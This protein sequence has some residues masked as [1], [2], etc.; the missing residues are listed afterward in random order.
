MGWGEESQG[1]ISE[2]HAQRVGIGLSGHHPTS[3]G[4]KLVLSFTRDASS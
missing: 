4:D 1:T 2:A 3:A